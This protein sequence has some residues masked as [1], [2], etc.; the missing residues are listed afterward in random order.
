MIH[1]LHPNPLGME[2]TTFVPAYRR[3]WGQGEDFPLWVW[4]KPKVFCTFPTCFG[5]QPNSLA[6]RT[7][8]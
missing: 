6:E 3:G 1:T 5:Y 4:A 8:T 7:F 2:Q